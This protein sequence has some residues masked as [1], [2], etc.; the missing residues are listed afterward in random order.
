MS[1]YSLILSELF[2]QNLKIEIF[3]LCVNGRSLLQNFEEVI[4][5][6]EKHLVSFDRIVRIIERSA[7][8]E[9]L[10]KEQ[11]REIKGHTLPCK[12]YEAKHK[13]MRVYMFQETGTGRIIVEG[14]IKIDGKS[15][16]KD[17][18]RVV[19]NIKNYLNQK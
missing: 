10:A 17:I 6:N 9:L 4:E 15:Q 12:I 11:F 18:K 3:E 13:M 19:N 5:N 16:V 2:T 8:L 14:T 1:K 7:N